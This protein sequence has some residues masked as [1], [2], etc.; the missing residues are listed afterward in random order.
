M[1]R[2]DLSGL[3]AGYV[4]QML[5]AY[6]D[7][8]A[9]VPIEWRELFERDPEAVAGSL[10][11]LAGLLRS[12]TAERLCHVDPAT[13]GADRE[14]RAPAPTVR[15]VAPSAAAVAPARPVPPAPPPSSAPGRART[16]G[17]GRPGRREA[18][19]ARRRDAPRRRRGGDGARQGLPDARASRRP[20]RPARLRADGRSGSRRVA[21]R[22][23]AD[24]GAPGADPGFAAPPLRR[25]RDPARG[26]AAPPRRLHG[27]DRLRDRAHLR[28]RRARLAPP[29]DRVGALP[30]AARRRRATVAPPP[31]LRGRRASSSTCAVR[32]SGRSS[33]RS[34]GSSRSCRCS[35]RRSR[36]RPRAA[37]TRS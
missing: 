14:P 4:A 13:P 3:N 31:S 7:A 28:S 8:P 9:S 27:L 32:S 19:R 23:V 10:P 25:R 35:T 6:L 21:A 33:S 15:S 22:A 36:S 20:A 11:G 29:G 18:V 34:R 12:R 26:V 16:G 5:E 2:A 24:A 30:A 37:P 17:R 1:S